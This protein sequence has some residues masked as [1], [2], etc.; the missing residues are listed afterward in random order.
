M[1]PH[2]AL[3]RFTV[4][5]T[6]RDRKLLL[7]M[8][9]LAG[10]CALALL[11]R[12]L[13][14]HIEG[15]HEAGERGEGLHVWVRYHMVL[16]HMIL[17]GS[18]PMMCMLYGPA[19]L[20]GEAEAGTLAYLFTRRLHRATV[21]VCRYFGVAIVLS[22]V[23]MAGCVA[24][25]GIAVWGDLGNLNETWPV[26]WRPPHDLGR[27]LWIVPLAVLAYLSVFSVMNL[28][29]RRSLIASGVYFIAFE[30]ALANMPIAAGQYS[31]IHQ[32]RKTLSAGT[33]GVSRLFNVPDL[34]AARL[35]YPA[36]KS[37]VAVLLLVIAV[38]LVVACILA[39]RRE[40]LASRVARD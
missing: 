20:V 8:I 34:A 1:T 40:L 27:Y 14:A 11:L 18:V 24:A 16:M 17:G 4:G 26:N 13:S 15:T 39:W 9:F 2:L 3:V 28:I 36:G 19:L 37:G 6:L 33:P 5:Q 32:L 38:L 25:H 30:V 22:L 23:A 35:L 31:I 21:L 7:A 29:T 12:I 10:P